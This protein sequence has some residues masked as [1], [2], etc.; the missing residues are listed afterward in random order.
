MSKCIGFL[1][2]CGASYAIEVAWNGLVVFAAP[3]VSFP[4]FLPCLFI[5]VHVMGQDRLLFFTVG[6]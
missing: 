1:L 2:Q 6:N 3:S 4:P 5:S